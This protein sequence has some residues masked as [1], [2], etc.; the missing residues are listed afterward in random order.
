ML[1]KCLTIRNMIASSQPVLPKDIPKWIQR[2]FLSVSSPVLLS[3]IRIL[4]R[5]VQPVDPIFSGDQNNQNQPMSGFP[6][7]ARLST[8]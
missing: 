6:L 1:S 3:R 7:M 2:Q 4:L 5:D 8:L